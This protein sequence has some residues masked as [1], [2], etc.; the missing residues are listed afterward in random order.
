MTAEN[1]TI[2]YRR[3]LPTRLGEILLASDGQ[4]L[5]GLYFFGQKGFPAAAADWRADTDAAPFGRTAEQLAS[6]LAGELRE[7]DVPV[8]LRGTPFQRSVWRALRGVLF[9]QTISYSELA[10]R[11]GVPKAVRAVG[12]AVGRNPV[13]VIVPC[14]RIVGADGSLTGYAGGLDRKRALLA[15]E[16]PR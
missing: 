3:T 13:S 8:A 11:A 14:H 2:T 4:C 16:R 9:G 7:F 1:V 12:A 5:T 10:G 15:H 6:Y